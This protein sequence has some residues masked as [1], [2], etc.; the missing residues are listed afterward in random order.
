MGVN[1]LDEEAIFKIAAAIPAQDTRSEYLHQVCGDDQALVSRVLN[2]LRAHEESASFL[3]SPPPG[4]AVTLDTPSISEQPGDQIGPYKLL[5]QIG[6]GGMG[7]VYMAEQLRPVKR[8]VALKIIKPG[9]DTRQVIARFEAERQ[10]LSLMDHPNIAK[11]LDAGTTSSGRPYFV[12]ELVKGQ[13]ITQYSDEHHL[14]PRQ[15]LKLLLP[16]CQAIQHAHQ[17]GIIHRD[18]KPTNILVA[19]YDQ[20]PVP[21]VIDFGVAKATSQPLTERTMFTGFGEVIGTLEYMSPEQA[22]VN[23]LDVDTRSDVYSLGVLLYELLTGSTPFDRSRL[24]TVAFDETLRIIREEEPPKPSTR[25]GSSDTLATI[26][27]T[28]NV[29][30]ARLTKLVRGELDWIVM[31]CLEKDRN[32]RYESAS[33]LAGDMQHYLHDEP[34]QACPHSTLYRLRKSA[35]RHKR[36]L[37]TVSAVAMAAL[38]AVAA[39]AVST[40]LVWRANQDLEREVYFQRITVAHRELSIGNAAAALRELEKCPEA[41]RDWE[42]HYLMRR[43]KVQPLIVHDS[44]EVYGVAFSPDAAR[45]ASVG[46]DGK[47][48]FWDS[49]SGAFLFE[50]SEAHRNA[51]CSV[52]FH[53]NG[54]YLAT[55]GAD[56]LVKVWDLETRQAVFQGQCDA[57]RN[58]GAS[59]TVA[60]R[61]PV[62]RHLA[63]GCDGRV[64]VWDWKKCRPDSPEFTFDGPDHDSIPVAFTRDGRYL[65]TGSAQPPGLSLWDIETG[66]RLCTLPADRHPVT[67]LAFN[68]DGDRLAAAS[69]GRYLSY[70]DTTAGKL[71]QT[72]PYDGNVLGIAISSDGRRLAS[73]GE[74]KRVHVWDPVTGREVLSLRGHTDMC[75]CVA[76]SPD[77]WRLASASHDKTIRVWDA[78]PLGGD[79]GEEVFTFTKHEHE[80]RTLAVSHDGRRIV[81]GGNGSLV[82]VWDAANGRVTLDFTGHSAPVFSVAW[83]PDGS[84]IATAGSAGRQ[85]DVRVWDARTGRDAFPPIPASRDSSAGPYQA[86]AF[87]PDGLYLVTG[88]VEGAVQVWDARTGNRINTLGSHDREIRAVVFSPN[89]KLFATA[90]GDGEVKLWDANRLNAKQ[91]PRILHARVPGPSVNIAFS[92]DSRRLATGEGENAVKIW[93]VETC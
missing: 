39:L 20:Q 79:E 34:V 60:F 42:W 33:A 55:A 5:Q 44:T 4:I 82:K 16:V 78:A 92:P 61:P 23:Q 27:A 74:D 72:I 11:V 25:L 32:Q 36:A 63:A 66:R 1:S 18:I 57:I 46:K 83:H 13:P 91:A 69:L 62:G 89:G 37:I 48:K 41:F 30:P 43:L 10:A 58:F 54:R 14:T 28:R 53:P 52:A 17:K 77:G 19:E 65:A 3:E 24:C 86:L 93:D 76:F 15:R 84:L 50:I 90:S 80:V 2:L 85:N 88:Q 56:R 47:I 22:K 68:A 73:S 59:C 51:A 31:K 38:L 7:V 70:W 6:E 67:A 45:I 12:M 81:S 8:R 26:A 49:R 64:R 75:G 21:M 35:G 9:M 71:L 87:S 40:G 29:E